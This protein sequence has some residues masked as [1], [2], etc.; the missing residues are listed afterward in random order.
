M[1]I[2]DLLGLKELLA[3][4]TERWLGGGVGPEGRRN[5]LD[6]IARYGEY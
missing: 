2:F 3:P 6:Y 1:E 4:S 5:L